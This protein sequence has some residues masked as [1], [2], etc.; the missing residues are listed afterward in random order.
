MEKKILVI[1]DEEMVLKSLDK[2]LKKSG[3]GVSTARNY[4]EAMQSVEQSDFNLIISDIRMAGKDGV[5]TVKSIR[6]YYKENKK[7][8]VPEILITGYADES[9]YN[10]AIEMGVS[11]YINKPFDIKELLDTIGTILNEG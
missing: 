9:K 10:E 2:L 8:A 4:D 6:Q 11:A 7:D 3:Y 1:D 5:E